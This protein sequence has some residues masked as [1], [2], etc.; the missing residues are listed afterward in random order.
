MVV[1][2]SC[3]A[4]IRGVAEDPVER[5]IDDLVREALG[6]RRVA[7][8]EACWRRSACDNRR[9]LHWPEGSL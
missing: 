6:E 3:P 1:N 7:V 4:L 2:I 9:T 5:E 8:Q